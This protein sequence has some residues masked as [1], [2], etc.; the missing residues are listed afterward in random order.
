M[1]YEDTTNILEF[2][3]NIKRDPEEAGVI[4]IRNPEDMEVYV[5]TIIPSNLIRT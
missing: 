4:E 1:F 5:V 2:E 3:W